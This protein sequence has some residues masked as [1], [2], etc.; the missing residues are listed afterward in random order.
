MKD[1]NEV[2][3][4]RLRLALLLFLSTLLTVLLLL[5]FHILMKLSSSFMR[6]DY[7]ASPLGCVVLL[8]SLLLLSFAQL[9]LISLCRIRNESVPVLI[10][11]ISKGVKVRF[12][13]AILTCFLT[14][15]MSF[16]MGL[17][18]GGEAPSVFMAALSFGLVFSFSKENEN[19]TTRALRVG[20]SVGFSLAFANPI[21]GILF[22]FVPS[23]WHKDYFKQEKNLII[24]GSACSVLG[25]CLYSCLKGLIY[26]STYKDCFYKAFL[27]NEFNYGLLNV[28]LASLTHYYIF[29][30]IPILCLPLSIVFVRFLSFLRLYHWKEK[31]SAYL[32][33]LV[34]GVILLLLVR[35]FIPE[36]L[37]TGAS[38]IESNIAY[39]SRGLMFIFEL[40]LARFVLVGFSFSSHFSGGNIIP[41]L[42]LGSIIGVFVAYLFASLLNLDSNT[43][44]LISYA[45]MISFF[46]FV[47]NKRE[48]SLSLLLS[49]GPSFAFLLAFIPSFIIEYLASRFIKGYSSLNKEFAKCDIKNNSYAKTLWKHYPL[50]DPEYERIWE[51]V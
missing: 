11:F 34:F 18:L 9:E 33:S 39:F 23:K 27:F 24:E 17:A 28:G 51:R 1:N 37:G 31:T 30:I 13:L 26:F 48:V 19:R 38:I 42:S 4:S 20:A 3:R 12:L 22:S 47:S 2:I 29:I 16:I 44:L 5:P 45:T 49:F 46:C 41:T 21:A 36:A 40:F 35:Y 50:Y 32:F 8:T 7:F 6:Q 14:C 43:C 25:Y 15:L 10:Y